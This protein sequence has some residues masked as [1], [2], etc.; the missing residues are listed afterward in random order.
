[1]AFVSQTISP[2]IILTLSNEEVEM[3]TKYKDTIAAFGYEIEP[4]GGKEYAITAIPAD[5]SDVD[6]RMMFIELLDEFSNLSGEQAPNLLL[7]KVAS[8]SC[9]AAVKGHDRLSVEEASHL[10]DTL[11]TL[12]N[13]YQC[14]HG[15]PTIIAMTQY[16]LEKK[17][18]RIV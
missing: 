8:M 15:R 12:E 10:I 3:L 6:M 18:K 11:L 17:F 4:F 5:F 1:M 7:E 9:K 14:P 13:P 16:E 2:P